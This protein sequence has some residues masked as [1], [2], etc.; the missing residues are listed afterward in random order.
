MIF[1][2]EEEGAGGRRGKEGGEVPAATVRLV[3]AQTHK[4][5]GRGGDGGEVG[6][7]GVPCEPDYARSEVWDGAEAFVKIGRLATVRG[8][9]GRGLGRVL[10]E[11]AMQFAGG[12]GREMVSGKGVGVW[13]GLVCAHAQVGVEGWY[14]G[15]GFVSD[16]GMGRWVEEGIEHVGVW[17]RV[18]VGGMRVGGGG[19]SS[20]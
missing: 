18:E 1:A 14:C 8:C 16:G 10:V 4:L 9:R 12:H 3:P 20:G 15:L 2:R 17:R 5:V 6:E 7:D 13:K 11:A 19:G